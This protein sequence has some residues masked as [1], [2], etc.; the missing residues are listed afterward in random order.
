MAVE[1]I[2]FLTSLVFWKLYETNLNYTSKNLQEVMKDGKYASRLYD[3]YYFENFEGERMPL[4]WIARTGKFFLP[5]CMKCHSDQFKHKDLPEISGKVQIDAHLF[6]EGVIVM[7]GK[8]DFQNYMTIEQHIKASIPTDVIL[9]QGSKS[10][11]D[12]LNQFAD[13]IT[14]FLKSKMKRQKG[15]LGETKAS[16]WHHNWIWWKSKPEIPIHEFDIGGKYEKWSLGMCTRSDKWPW[17]NPEKYATNIEAFYNLSPYAGNCVY[18]THPGNCIIPSKQFT[19]PNSVKNTLIDVL[20]AAELGNVQRYLILNHLQDFNFKSLEIQELL[21][22][23]EEEESISLKEL[24][25]RLEDIEEEINGLVLEINY[26]LQVTRTPRLIFTSVFKT[27]LFRQMIDSLHGFDFLNSLESIISE[28]KDSLSRERDVVGI[29]VNEAENVFLRNLQ[30][31]FI[32]ELIASM[33]G[34]FYIL[35]DFTWDL[36][37][38]F[39]IISIIGSL[40]ILYLLKRVK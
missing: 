4:K 8:L 3:G 2:S 36:G 23:F 38:I 26:D 20:F 22:K 24:I 27:K 14:Q 30:I 17:L 12:T 16:P 21:Y 35:G 29:K 9:T 18:I 6:P 39:I 11:F 5:I 28:I 40:G 32:V 31:V 7:Q 25:K 37:M 10:L 15:E 19:D 1:E 13:E 33:I 34:L